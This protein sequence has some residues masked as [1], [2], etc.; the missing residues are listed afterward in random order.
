[1]SRRTVTHAT[2]TIERPYDAGPERVFGAFADPAIKR[3]W[4]A[5]SEGFHVDSYELDF[6]VGGSERACFRFVAGKPLA[7]GTPCVN[8]TVFMDI[9]PER[10]IVFAYTMTIDGRRISSSHSTVEFLPSGSGTELIFTEQAAFFEGADR[11]KMREQ[12]TRELL[13]HLAEE[14]ENR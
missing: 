6:R 4:F 8:D 9:V 11:P 14:L 1:M 2:F 12:G 10:R 7:E 5:E 13:E 3:R